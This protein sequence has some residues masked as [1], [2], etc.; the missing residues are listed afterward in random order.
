M[1]RGPGARRI[2][3]GDRVVSGTHDGARDG[4]TDA[5]VRPMPRG[6]ESLCEGPFRGAYLALRSKQHD[7]GEQ[8]PQLRITKAGDRLL[9]RLL[10]SA[11]HYIPGPFGPDTELRRAGLRMAERAGKAAKKRAEV[12]VARRLALLLHRL[13]VTGEEYEPLRDR[14]ARAAWTDE[15]KTTPNPGDCA[16]AR[17][18]WQE[19]VD[20]ELAA[21][22]GRSHRGCG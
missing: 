16:V 6:P 18:P 9:R 19:E 5:V 20:N 10:V 11:A 17:G 15:S 1:D 8:Q 22:D 14:P 4:G 7:S 3:R 2:W 12:A 13:W 21:P